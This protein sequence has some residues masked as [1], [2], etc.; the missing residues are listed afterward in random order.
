MIDEQQLNINTTE[1]KLL[2]DI[3]QELREIKE[4]LCSIAKNT[5]PKEEVKPKKIVAKSKVTKPKS[6]LVKKA[7]TDKHPKGERKNEN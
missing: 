1:A 3:R 5:E 7:V 4:A 2:F 6:K